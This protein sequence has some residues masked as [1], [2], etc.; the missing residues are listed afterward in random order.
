MAIALKDT[1]WKFTGEVF[2]KVGSGW[3]PL[4]G[5]WLKV[6]GSWVQ[7]FYGKT[8]GWYQS[9]FDTCKDKAGKIWTKKE[10]TSFFGDIGN[11]TDKTCIEPHNGP[12]SRTPYTRDQTIDCRQTGT[13]T[14]VD[15]SKCSQ[16]PPL[17][18]LI[19]TYDDVENC[20]SEFRFKDYVTYDPIYIQP[21]S[22]LSYLRVTISGT[23]DVYNYTLVKDTVTKNGTMSSTEFSYYAT[24]NGYLYLANY[25]EM[26]HGINFPELSGFYHCGIQSTWYKTKYYWGAQM[27]AGMYSVGKYYVGL[28]CWKNHTEPTY[29]PY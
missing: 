27:K 9:G 1:T 26:K 10:P 29:S 6:S 11:Q 23:P 3:E 7:V 13:S 17:T 14:S 2:Y 15:Y 5:V 18:Q 16:P 24:Y 8:Y 25:W 28:Q 21:I 22:D 4:K 12:T 20:I 19:C